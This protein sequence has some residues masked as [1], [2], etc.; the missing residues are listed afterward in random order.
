MTLLGNGRDC[1]A[2]AARYPD[3]W[4]GET[5]RSAGAVVK[6]RCYQSPVAGRLEGNGVHNAFDEGAR[7]RSRGPRDRSGGGV[8][9][10][11]LA[12]S[13]ARAP[14]IS[15]TAT[16]AVD[17]MTGTVTVT[18]KGRVVGT[19]TVQ[20]FH[21]T[22][23]T[24]TNVAAM[25]RSGSTWKAEF[26]GVPS[27][28]QMFRVIARSGSRT[29]GLAPHMYIK[30]Y[31]WWDAWN[32]RQSFGDTTLPAAQFSGSKSITFADAADEC[33]AINLGLKGGGSWVSD[34]ADGVTATVFSDVTPP[35]V[36]TWSAPAPSVLQP[37]I[38]VRGA[39][40]VD[41]KVVGG[42]GYWTNNGY[43]I[44]AQLKCVYQP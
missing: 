43:Y 1:P 7:G 5:L 3:R 30:S 20:W 11:A 32:S 26:A 18:T 36:V 23:K 2:V 13:P 27:G 28:T 33:I 41:T 4:R 31:A 35:T 14:K 17:A 42:E 6:D 22:Q 40:I 12:I 24:W 39:V 29:T 34:P 25:T 21:P 15:V 38:P 19:P 9:P 8:A 37:G 10:S 44:G 16:P